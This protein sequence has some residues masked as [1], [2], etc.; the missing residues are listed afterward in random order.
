MGE[1]NRRK[2]YP[3]GTVVRRTSGI[4]PESK[5][6]KNFVSDANTIK[7]ITFNGDKRFLVMARVG[8][9]SLHKEWLEPKEY[10]NFDLYLEYFGDGSNDY[11]NDCDFYAEA[12][13]T[14]WPRFYKVIEEFGE[15][16]FKYDAI[17]MPDDDISTDCSTIN[18][19][20]E[21]FMMYNLS[22]A[23]PALTSD[24]YFSHNITLERS[25]N[26]LRFTKFV[27]VMVPIFSREAL[28]LC[29]STFIKSKSGWGLDS[30]WP[31]LLGY[32]NDKMAIIDK[33]P[34]KHTRP[35]G[36]GTLYKDAYI[37]NA[38][39]ER[40]RVCKKY[41]VIQQFDYNTYGCVQKEDAE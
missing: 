15:Q 9:T 31:K 8:D 10:K 7:P 28:Q 2:I 12:K 29:W 17:W 6:R 18:E 35:M 24:S 22:L 3:S 38:A 21:I 20:F 41:G 26:I 27:E 33:L 34:V 32:P 39:I 11:K 1:K 36:T 5:R 14:K 13:D 16:V 40:N 37:N 19:I 4:N 30:T 25:E 23:Q